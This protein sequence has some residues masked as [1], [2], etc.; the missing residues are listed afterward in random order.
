MT[1]YKYNFEP[2]DTLDTNITHATRKMEEDR[3][4][5]NL[6]P[7]I[8]ENIAEEPAAVPKQ[9][10]RRFV[11]RKTVEKAAAGEQHADANANIEDSSAIQG[12]RPPARDSLRWHAELNHCKQWPSLAVLL[13]R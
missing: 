5:T 4:A 2:R 9:P 12:V 8:D 13:V 6:G 1:K 10:K 7:D 3:A 11:G